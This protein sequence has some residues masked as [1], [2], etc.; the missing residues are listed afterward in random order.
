M[1]PFAHL[2]VHSEYSLL[3]GA[4]RIPALVQRAGELGMEAVAL[5]D[6][7]TLGGAVE[8]YRAATE[9]GHGVKPIIG[10]ELYVVNDR[11]ARGG[12]KERYHH[13]TLLATDNE[14]YRNLVK[15]STLAFL[16]GYYYKP[17]ADWELLEQYHSGL[18][19]L[20][21]CMSGR[22]PVA[23]RDGREEDARG[24]PR[25]PRRPLRRRQR[26]RRAAGRRPA[27]AARAVTAARRAGGAGR[28]ADRRH[29][30]RALPAP[31]GLLRPRRPALHPDPELPR[32]RGPHAPLERRVLPQ[33]AR[34]DGRALHRVPRGAARPRRDR[35]ALQRRRSSSAPTG[36]PRTRC[37]TGTT[38]SSYLRELCEA[39]LRAPL[40][41]RRPAR[42][43]RAPR[44]TSSASSPRWASTPTS[45]SSGTSSTSPSAPASRSGPAAGRPPARIVSYCARHHRHRPAQVRP[46]LRALPQPRPQVDARHRHRLLGASAASEVIE[47]VAEKYGRDRVAQIIT[48]GTMAARAAVRDAAR[49]MG[50]P[51]GV[52]DRIAKMIPEQAPPAT[53]EEA[54]LPGGELRP[55]YDSDPQVKQ[56][57]DLA[58]SLEGLIRNDSIHA[59]GGGH[60][61]P[62]ADRVRAAA[63]EGRRRGRDPVRMDDVDAARPAQDGLPRPA[64]PRRHRGRPQDHRGHARRAHRHGDAA[65]RRREDLRHA[66]ARRLHGRVPVRVGGHARRPPRGRPDRVR[67]PHRHRRALPA[68]GRCSTS[69]P[70]RATRRTRPRSSTTTRPCARSSRRPT[71]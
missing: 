36:C 38:E 71:G 27:R 3:D 60:Q 34:G 2:H 10:L 44:A 46:A 51:Y 56:V 55:A 28:P 24:R 21:G 47:Y 4:C 42:G 6:H 29:Q 62:A 37:P 59:A 11:R 15:L 61:R 40:R 19:C 70:T 45:S 14:G 9:G 33:V 25:P 43:P 16:E 67:G 65:A 17:R 1:A 18:I 48:F 41:R 7:G 52:G 26:L 39:G 58:M 50:L 32:R 23:L 31:R 66:R 63:A 22:V 49:V 12:V 57:V 35:R 13:L 30:R 69:R 5:T 54:M 64:Q 68:R 20:T 8:F 53:F